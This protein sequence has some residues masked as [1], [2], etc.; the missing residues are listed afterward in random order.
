MRANQIAQLAWACLLVL[1]VIAPFQNALAY[2]CERLAELA[3]DARAAIQ[4]DIVEKGGYVIAFRHSNKD[5]HPTGRPGS[6]TADGEQA[7]SDAYVHLGRLLRD[8]SGAR[9]TDRVLVFEK[10]FFHPRVMQTRER[11]FMG[12]EYEKES[13]TDVEAWYAKKM[14]KGLSLGNRNAFLVA[15]NKVLKKLTCNGAPCRMGCLEGLALKP[16]ASGAFQQCYRFFP[17]EWAAPTAGVLPEWVS[18]TDMDVTG[19]CAGAR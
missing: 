7:A 4:K 2:S 14:R 8:D 5:E 16:D 3:P 15:T 6:L 10:E 13:I 12:F 11:L 9:K 18:N 19:E 1:L 17:S